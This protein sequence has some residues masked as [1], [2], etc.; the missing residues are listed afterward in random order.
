MA[1][2]IAKFYF[3]ENFTSSIFTKIKQANKLEA[4]LFSK[5]RSKMKANNK[6]RKVERNN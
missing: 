1:K 3:C 5:V 4:K 2:Q 6:K